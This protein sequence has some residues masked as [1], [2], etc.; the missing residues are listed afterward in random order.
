M[1]GQA[2]GEIALLRL[3]TDFYDSTKHELEQLYPRLVAGGV[4]LIDDYG[5]YRGS[6]KATDEVLAGEPIFLQRLDFSAR[7]GVKQRASTAS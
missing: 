3:D 6:K 2:P 1:P 7:M 5:H 4:L